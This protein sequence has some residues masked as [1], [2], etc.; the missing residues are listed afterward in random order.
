FILRSQIQSIRTNLNYISRDLEGL[1]LPEV[2]EFVVNFGSCLEEL[3]EVL[4]KSIWEWKRNREADERWKDYFTTMLLYSSLIDA[5]KKD[6]GRIFEKLPFQRKAFKLSSNLI[7]SYKKK[8]F[9]K[10]EPTK[11]NKLRSE[12]SKAVERRLED[13]LELPLKSGI[14]TL[15]APTGSG[16]TLLGLYAAL[17][18][19]EKLSHRGRPPRIIYCLPYINII[20]QTHLTLMRVLSSICRDVPI[21]LLLK[22]HHLALPDLQKFGYGEIPL[23]TLLLLADSWESEIVVTTFVQLFHSLIGCRNSVLKKFHNIANSII[24]LDEVQAL[25]LG[26]W[27]LV[28]DLLTF[29][30]RELNVRIIFMTATMPIIFH[31]RPDGGSGNAVELVPN[32]KSYFNRLDRTIIETH[33]DEEM[34]V[35]DFVEFFLSKWTGSESVLIVL[36]TIK[37]SKRVYRQIKERLRDKVLSLSSDETAINR[38]K[39]LITYLSTS[40]V[41]KERRKRIEALKKRL[42]EGCK[43]ILVSTQVVEAGVD[44]DFDMAIRDLGPLDSIVQVAGRCN[45]NWRLRHGYLHVV[46]VV[47]EKGRPDC[48]KIYGKILPDIT[49]NL[50]RKRRKITEQDLVDVVGEYYREASYRM[51]VEKSPESENLLKNIRNLDYS[52]LTRFSLIKEEP[53]IPVFIE[54]DEEAKHIIN[55]FKEIRDKV[56]NEKDPGKIFTYRAELRKVKAE[57]EKY[58]VNIWMNGRNR[59]KIQSLD[60]IAPGSGIL[61]VP[62]NVLEAYYDH[63]VG[64][65]EDEEDFYLL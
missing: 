50:L 56:K 53:K 28:K 24:I 16:K 57:M 12:L 21:T 43:A 54:L 65:K 47:D 38:S 30:T 22:H 14:L 23:D 32:Y 31:S 13:V 8:E 64:F 42:K 6:A 26:Y 29:L 7:K 10:L 58:I 35:E 11:I 59:S 51:N 37:T 19:R 1:H 15:T 36:N 9:G 46:K 49:Q 2:E 33:L 34:T 27:R 25:P 52:G 3:R 60:Q 5:D 41:P 45:R 17:R 62:H 48:F 44:L 4:G 55:Q 63:E 40:V 20:E 61:Y 39:I 18:L